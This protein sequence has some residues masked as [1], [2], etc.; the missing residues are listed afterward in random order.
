MGQRSPRLLETL[1]AIE[2]GCLAEGRAFSPTTIAIRLGW[3]W[4]GSAA[5]GQRVFRLATGKKDGQSIGTSHEQE[6]TIP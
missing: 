4:S 5:Q 1:L 2:D 6:H 3:K